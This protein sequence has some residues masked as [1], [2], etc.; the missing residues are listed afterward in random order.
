VVLAK[1]LA[2]NPKVFI[3]DSPTV[4]IDIASKS[5]IHSIIRELANRGMGIIIISDEIPEVL[6][7]CNRILIMVNGEVKK[8]IDNVEGVTEE[9]IFKVVS[10]QVKSEVV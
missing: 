7:N 9:E 10:S 8:I 5:N 1:W 6:T 4:G 3:L 2:T